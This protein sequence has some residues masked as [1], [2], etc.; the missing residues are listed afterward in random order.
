MK[1]ESDFLVQLENFDHESSIAARY[2]Y[3]EMAMQHAASK[4]QKLL[5]RLNDT[6]TFWIVCGASLQ[7]SAYITIARIFDKKSKYNIDKL[8]DSMEQSLDLFQCKALAERKRDG[9][10]ID[11]EW[12]EEYLKSAYFP[13][14]A[15][16]ARLRKMVK[17]YREIYNRA[18]MPVRH[19][20]LAHR[21]EVD[22]EKVQKLYANGKISELRRLSTFLLQLRSVLWQQYHNGKKPV[23]RSVRHS[24]KSIY[25]AEHQ[26]NSPNESIVSDV[27][28]L[29]KFIELAALDNNKK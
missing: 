24:V 2:L 13:I 7:S 28:K 29:M 4:S 16:I 21:G 23:F 19:N 14:V 1:S 26:G 17:K 27:K 3:A 5:D 12:L 9:K 11:P 18:V 22:R 25:D 8:L 20:Y 15:D 6:P 10:T